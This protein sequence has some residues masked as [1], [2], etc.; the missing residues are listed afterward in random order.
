MPFAYCRQN[1]SGV[2]AKHQFAEGKVV[3]TTCETSIIISNPSADDPVQ[4]QSPLCPCN[5]AGSQGHRHILI[6]EQ[7][8]SLYW[9]L[10]SL[11]RLEQRNSGCHLGQEEAFPSGGI[12]QWFGVPFSISRLLACP[13]KE[14]RVVTQCQG[15]KC[16]ESLLL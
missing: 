1:L 15:M 2:I 14:L 9:V 7:Q 3:I 8:M 6:L 16:R 11:L 12:V 5:N 10:H 13:R 4:T